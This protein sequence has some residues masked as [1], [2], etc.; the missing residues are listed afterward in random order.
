MIAPI[1]PAEDVQLLAKLTKTG[2]RFEREDIASVR[3]QPVV[4]GVAAII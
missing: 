3:L 4:K 2:S 1:G